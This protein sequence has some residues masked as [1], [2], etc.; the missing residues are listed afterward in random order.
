MM[1]LRWMVVAGA[2]LASSLIA[3]SPAAAQSAPPPRASYTQAQADSGQVAF[4]QTCASCHASDLSGA[5]GPPLVGAPFA[6]NWAG[7]FAT[8]LIG[9]IKV[10]EPMTKPGTTDEP[11][12]TLLVAYILYMN[13]VP[14]STEP[15]NL[16]DRAVIILPPRSR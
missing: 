15:L 6:Y 5:S 4:E 9:H 7:K 8:G 14:A 1:K 13:G 10:N 12:A 11:T 3:V 16:T 2:V